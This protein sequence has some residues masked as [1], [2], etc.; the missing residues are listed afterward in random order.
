MI[1]NKRNK[2]ASY[3]NRMKKQKSKK[4]R[5]GFGTSGTTINVPT[6][7]S[8]RNLVLEEEGEQEVENLFEQ[9]MTENFPNLAKETDF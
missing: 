9:I 6:S 3:Q 2:Q 1:W 8:W 4:M 5:R 7:E